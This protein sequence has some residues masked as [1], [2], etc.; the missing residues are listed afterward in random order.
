MILGYPRMYD[1]TMALA[2]T[3]LTKGSPFTVVISP[4]IRRQIYCK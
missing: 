4:S 1:F 2:I 3:N